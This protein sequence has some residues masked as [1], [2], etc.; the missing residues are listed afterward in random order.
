MKKILFFISAII[1][2]ISCGEKGGKQPELTLEEKL[3]ADWHST[4]LSLDADVYISFADN[5]T[6][7]LYQKIVEGA[8]RLYRGTWNL[9]EDI[10]TGKYN[11]GEDWAAAYQ[12]SID[13]ETLTMTSKNDAAEVSVYKKTVI[14]SSVKETS[15]TIVK[16]L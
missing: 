10:L 9:E 4:S 14:P 6:F 13:G 8:Y 12:I 11:D 3:C 7:E 16:S 5:N 15:E 2:L 1:L